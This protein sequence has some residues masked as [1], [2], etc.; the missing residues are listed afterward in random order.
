LVRGLCGGGFVGQMRLK[1]AEGQRPAFDGP[2]GRLLIDL[3]FLVQA[4]GDAAD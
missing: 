1:Q 2:P 4:P 3:V